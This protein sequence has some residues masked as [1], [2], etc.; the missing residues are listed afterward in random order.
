VSLILFSRTQGS[1]GGLNIENLITIQGDVIEKTIPKIKD[2]AKD[3]IKEIN[4]TL[5]R[6]G[7]VRDVASI[8]G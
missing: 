6:Q 3:V 7:S 5:V 1:G 8:Y 4:S 2:I